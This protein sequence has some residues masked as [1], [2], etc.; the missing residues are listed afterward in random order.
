MLK[1]KNLELILKNKYKIAV[2]QKTLKEVKHDINHALKTKIKISG[3]SYRTGR[4]K[5][6]FIPVNTLLNM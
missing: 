2:G 1:L 6:I 3:R 5:V 4:K